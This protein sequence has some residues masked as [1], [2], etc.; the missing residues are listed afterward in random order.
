M[1][2]YE[3][4]N[5]KKF[6][7]CEQKRQVSDAANRPRAWLQKLVNFSSESTRIGEGNVQFSIR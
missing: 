6:L 3:I 4:L 1:W 5:L 2:P 7:D